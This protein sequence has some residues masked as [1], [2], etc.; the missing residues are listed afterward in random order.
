[1][2]ETIADRVKAAGY[3]LPEPARAA[4][5]YVP[6]RRT[7]TLL[8]VAGQIGRGLTT[9]PSARVGAE[10]DIDQAREA[11]AAAGLSV[12]AQIAAATDG[13]VSAV[14]SIQRL[15]VFIAATP[16][17]TQH[18]EVANAA[19][20]LLVAV[21]GEAGRHARSAVG[22]SSLPRGAAVEIEAVV[23]LAD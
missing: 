1:M 2:T 3:D 15:S 17:F 23:E 14:R 10:L 6:F 16:D 13:R 7:G 18:P 11:A 22:V 12:L 4:G 8:H 21:L 20:D 9:A 5:N 19:S